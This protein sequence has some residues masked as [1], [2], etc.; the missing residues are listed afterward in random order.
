MSS[1]L[2]LGLQ[3]AATADFE[4]FYA[5]PNRITVTRLRDWLTD[6]RGGL[7]YLMGEFGTG[8]SHLLQACCADVSR[9]N[10]TSLYLPIEVT[11]GRF[12]PEVLLGLES[13][14]LVAVDDLPLLAAAPAWQAALSSLMSR[15]IERGGRMVVSGCP[16]S[17]MEDP[18]L[19]FRLGMAATL[20]LQSLSDEDKLALLQQ[21]ARAKGMKL[22]RDVARYL[23]R[24]Q[25]DGLAQLLSTLDALDYASLAAKRRLTVPFVSSVLR[26]KPR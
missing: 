22:P 17:D 24:H 5:G 13:V 19:R 2:P 14:D 21:R 12:P 15:V 25:V 1:Q 6:P 9:R 20:P 26:R 7:A 10:G 3:V 16:G 23:L 8:R 18:G 4:S 11:L